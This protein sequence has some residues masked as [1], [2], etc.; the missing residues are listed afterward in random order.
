[1]VEGTLHGGC[2]WQLA[3]ADLQLIT[4]ALTCCL[5]CKQHQCVIEPSIIVLQLK[6]GVLDALDV[7]GMA[8]GLQALEELPMCLLDAALAVQHQYF[9][10]SRYRKA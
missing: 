3:A 4:A 9:L 7:Y 6:A 1:V 5:G 10:F 8:L 2:N